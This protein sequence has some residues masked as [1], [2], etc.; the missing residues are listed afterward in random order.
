[1]GDQLRWDAGKL[2]LT[3]QVYTYRDLKE[4]KPIIDARRLMPAA[5]LG[6]VV[7]D[8]PKLNFGFQHAVGFE[9]NLWGE[10]VDWLEQRDPGVAAKVTRVRSGPWPAWKRLYPDTM[11]GDAGPTTIP[12]DLH[13]SMFIGTQAAD[14]FTA[15][16]A[17][18]PCFLHV[19]FVDPHHPFD[20]P[21]EIA[22]KYPADR[23]P[24]PRYPDCGDV[25]WPASLA[26]RM[27]SQQ[28]LA[29]ATPDMVRTTIGLYYGMIEMIDRGVGELLAAVEQAG[30]MDNTVFVFVADHGEL[31]GDCGLWRKGSYHYDC[32]MRVPCFIAAPRGAGPA[33]RIEDLVQAI[34]LMPT[35][36]SMLGLPQPPGVQGRD[37]AQPLAAGH[38][39]AKEWIYCELFQAAAGPYVDVWTIRTPQAKLSWFPRDRTGLL[40][41][42]AADPDER[43]DRFADPACVS[44]RDELTATLLEEIRMQNDPLPRVLSQW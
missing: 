9:D 38:S 30:Q 6:D 20:P 16:H 34:D 2:H 33:R 10:Y 19:S 40:F 24:M 32:L 8:E 42:L 31:L 4:D 39:V 14:W 41:D 15:H 29:T 13:P 21:E 22:A 27:P 23:M 26:A 43:R 3:P 25:R 17:A 12:P 1:M 18:G 35:L 44:L 5:Q 36:L 28:A 37:L 11:L 7:F